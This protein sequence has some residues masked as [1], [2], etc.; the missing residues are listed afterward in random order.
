MSDIS[1]KVREI[2]EEVLID[3]GDEDS[4]IREEYNGR[5]MFGLTCFGIVVPANQYIQAIESA[6]SRGLFGAKVD[7]MGLSAIVYW[8]YPRIEES[9]D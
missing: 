6:A 2:L 8:P 4:S 3:V 7:Q 1:T 5:N 9:N